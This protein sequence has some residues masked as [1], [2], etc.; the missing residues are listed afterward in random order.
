MKHEKIK[1]T[2]S[3]SFQTKMTN[4][5][6]VKMAGVTE[7]FVKSCSLPS[8]IKKKNFW[9]IEKDILSTV[10]L[11]LFEPIGYSYYQQFKQS[12]EL[13][14]PLK[15]EII[16]VD[17]KGVIQIKYKL[18]GCVIKRIDQSR[19]E[20]SHDQPLVT[21]IEFQPKTIEIIN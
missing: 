2:R 11:E 12:S 16:Q 10:M 3:K 17:P 6:T 5:W 15:M 13:N 1:M 21:K 18:E 19:L 9:G 20:Y 4:L 14:I 7:D 8:I